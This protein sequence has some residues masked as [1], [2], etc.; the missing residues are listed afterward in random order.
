MPKPY[1]S[2]IV[3]AT[4]DEVWQLVRLFDGL[5]TWH[6]GIA[7]SELTHGR[8]GMV[9]AVRRLVLGDG[10]AVVERLV[11]LDDDARTLTYDFVENPFGARRYVSTIRL[12]P[13]TDTGQTFVEW[14]AEFDADGDHEEKLTGL[15][16]DG[17]YGTGISALQQRFA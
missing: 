12:A 1:R 6:P 13:V 5:P 4:I 15:F 10:A 3:P 7:T 8:E 11:A 16:R 17:V 14:W 9:G 2:G